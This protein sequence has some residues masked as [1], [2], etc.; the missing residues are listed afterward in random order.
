[1][2]G[3]KYLQMK[4]ILGKAKSPVGAAVSHADCFQKLVK[5]HPLLRQFLTGWEEDKT[6]HPGGFLGIFVNEDGPKAM[7][8]HEQGG[9]RCF[10]TAPELVDLLRLLEEGLEHESLDWRLVKSN[11]PSKRKG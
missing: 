4:K 2:G 6:M 3:M 11:Q 7:L 9:V 1:M 10:V 8:K 5:T